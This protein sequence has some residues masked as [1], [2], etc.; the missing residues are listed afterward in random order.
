MT[1]RMQQRTKSYQARSLVL[2]L[3]ALMLGLLSACSEVRTEIVTNKQSAA[4]SA[5]RTYGTID[6][7]SQRSV[8]NV[9]YKQLN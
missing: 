1:A 9:N 3:G 2:V 8:W 5:S 4:D 6:G 7:T